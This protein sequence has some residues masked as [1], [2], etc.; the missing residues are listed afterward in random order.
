[1]PINVKTNNASVSTL[2]DLNK[3]SR[4]LQRT[5]ERISSGQRIARAADD[6]A[7]LGVAENL[8]AAHT[9]A[10]VA[11]RNTN[12]GISVISVAEGATAE[13]G[14]ILV[15]MRELAVQGAS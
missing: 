9:S 10:A 12:D 14:S 3:T 8:R 13:V 1:M 7:G 4:A 15:R 2:N 5:F 6:A 11:A